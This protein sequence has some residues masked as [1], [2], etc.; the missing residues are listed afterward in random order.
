MVP[1]PFLG[2]QTPA[3]GRLSDVVR[4]GDVIRLR[5]WREPDMSG[6]FSVSPAGRVVLPRLGELAL[7]SI[8]ADSLQSVLTEKYRV[9]LNNPSIEVALL[10]RV[11]VTGAVRNPG[12]Y[13]LESTMSISDAVALAGGPAPDGKRDKVEVRRGGKRIVADLRND[14]ILADTPVQSGDQIY[15][16]SRAWLSRNTWIISASVTLAAVLIREMSR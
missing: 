2:A 3:I 14:V 7:S 6:E 15:V 8:P 10:R 11:T 13:P 16:P 1:A 4:P 5:I 9:Y 12:V